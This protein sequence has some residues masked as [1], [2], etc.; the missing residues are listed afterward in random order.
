M[1]NTKLVLADY[2]EIYPGYMDK[3]KRL[4]I[5]REF[6]GKLKF[7][8]ESGCELGEKKRDFRNRKSTYEN[9]S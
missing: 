8:E 6:E 1:Y 7:I 9:V 4:E 2:R 3:E 5:K